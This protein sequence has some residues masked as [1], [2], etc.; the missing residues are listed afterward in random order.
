MFKPQRSSERALR[1]VGAALLA[2]ALLSAFGP[3]CG[4]EFTGPDAVKERLKI[5]AGQEVNGGIFFVNQSFEQVLR[6]RPERNGEEIDLKV[7]RHATGEDPGVFGLSFDRSTLF[8]VNEQRDQQGASLSLFDTGQDTLSAQTISLDSPYDRL[9]ADPAGEFL[10]LHFSGDSGDFIARNLNEVGII[11]LRGDDLDGS[12]AQFETL[13][14]RAR[15]VEFAPPFELAGERQ[16][17][18]AAL[19]PSAVTIIDLL[20]EDPKNRLREVPLTI[21][22][23]DQVRTPVQAIFDVS[24]AGQDEGADESASLY[25]LSDIGD[26]ITRVTIQASASER[27]FDLSVNQLAAGKDPARMQLLDLGEGGARLIAIDG[28]QPR[29]T[30]VDVET[31][32]SATFELPMTAAATDL[33]VYQV[34]DE[35]ASEPAA[36]TRVLAWSER[37]NLAA[38]IRPESIAV[39]TQTP[40][41]GRSVEAI[42]LENTP[43]SVRLDES[44]S[45]ARAV[46]RYSGGLRA[47]FAML[48]LENNRAIPV[49]GASLGALFFGEQYAYGVFRGEPYF[50]VFDLETGHPSTFELPAEGSDIYLDEA[51]ELVVVQHGDPTGSFTLLNALN[52]SASKARVFNHIF[53]EDLFEQELP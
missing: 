40:T 13:S 14:N 11:D 1:R 34:V 29:F 24:A 48:D 27:K 43:E 32:E 10:L 28:S 30:M 25:L 22:Q 15:G 16:R 6:L 9:S 19:S 52:P 5:S 36:E 50:G 45:A 46:V 2:S 38:V 17:L 41:L 42:R 37:S 8:V 4:P 51:S 12:A 18:A 44:S 20:D 47:G 3:G 26:D 21:S 33:L 31:G 39:N 7:D 49:Q 35:R 23:A 53:I